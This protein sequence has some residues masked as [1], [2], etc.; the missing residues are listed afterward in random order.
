MRIGEISWDL[1]PVSGDAGQGG[2]ANGLAPPSADPT[3]TVAVTGGNGGNAPF[4]TG[5]GRGATI[6]NGGA[7]PAVFGISTSGVTVTVLGTVIGGNGGTGITGGSGSS[8]GLLSNGSANDAI[9]GATSGALNLTQT[10]IGGNGGGATGTG[11]AGGNASSVLN[12]D[13]SFGASSYGSI[14]MQRA[15]KAEQDQEVFPLAV[16]QPQ[17][18]SLLVRSPEAAS[19]VLPQQQAGSSEGFVETVLTR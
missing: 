12:G 16:V 9:G 17:A 11:G 2:P 1:R 4:G 8:V 19:Q 13:N 3:N 15:E 10:S 5:G 14:R 6:S 7:G 18:S